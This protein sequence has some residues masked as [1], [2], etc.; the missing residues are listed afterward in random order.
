MSS[1]RHRS[2]RKKRPASDQQSSG[3]RQIRRRSTDE[4]PAVTDVTQGISAM[5]TTSSVPI[6]R[7]NAE[8]Q[9]P[10]PPAPPGG[11]IFERTSGGYSDNNSAYQYSQH[12]GYQ[13][14]HYP[15]YQS[16]QQPGS[17]PR[18]QSGY[19]P[20][21]EFGYQY[22]AYADS[23][24]DNTSSRHYRP[25][26]P[27]LNDGS[28]A[29]PSIQSLGLPCLPNEPSRRETM[30]HSQ[31]QSGSQA[32]AM[33]GEGAGAT[34]D[35]AYY[36]PLANRPP[37]SRDIEHLIYLLKE[38]EFVEARRFC[39]AEFER[40]EVKVAKNGVQLKGITK[41]TKVFDKPMGHF[42]RKRMARYTEGD[43]RSF[44]ILFTSAVN[45]T[46]YHENFEGDGPSEIKAFLEY[47]YGRIREDPDLQRYSDPSQL[48]IQVLTMM[49]PLDETHIR[50]W[51]METPAG[52]KYFI[53]P[54]NIYLRHE[55]VLSGLLEA[56]S[57]FGK[58]HNIRVT[59]FPFL[60][61][62]VNQWGWRLTKRSNAGQDPLFTHLEILTEW[63]ESDKDGDV[64]RI[65]VIHSFNL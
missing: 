21:H 14:G 42:V 65:E 5:S 53:R 44:W 58:K 41:S 3:N 45:T 27:L 33:G 48:S 15:G 43:Y 2:D 24:A 6:G 28:Q 13:T 40:A 55:E 34:A 23:P 57:K 10:W 30:P 16:H 7:I 56:V 36:Q 62:Y 60:T 47:Q 46:F 22:S 39:I 19:Q 54:I 4:D 9:T 1:R 11:Y 37:A 8:N 32:S 49:Q 64:E 25:G 59:L 18:H 52:G 20:M 29:L 12:A 63:R 38:R 61:S 26:P 51:V 17:Q 50:R 31:H 35:G